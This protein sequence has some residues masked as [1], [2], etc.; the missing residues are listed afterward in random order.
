MG[1]CFVSGTGAYSCLPSDSQIQIDG[2]TDLAFSED[3]LKRYEAYGWHTSTV[4]NG[5]EAASPALAAAV[6]AAKAV[7]DKP[8]IIKVRTTIGLGSGKQG[9]EKVHG[10]P[11]GAEDLASVKRHYGFNP[12]ESFV[13]PADVASFF[14]EKKVESAKKEEAWKAK[15][16]VC[17][18]GQTTSC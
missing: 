17:K 12:E 1:S 15:F 10:S 18:R 16:E 11:L 3:V 4:E 9:T 2:S 13:V 5:D 14:A 8:S 7:T 6:E